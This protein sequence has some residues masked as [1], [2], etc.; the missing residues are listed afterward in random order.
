MEEILLPIDCNKT[1]KYI[2]TSLL[3][4]ASLRF[5]YIFLQL[6]SLECVDVISCTNWPKQR[7]TGGCSNAILLVQRHFRICFDGLYLMSAGYK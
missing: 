1:E 6:M 5:L 3:F 4:C 2:A 7:L